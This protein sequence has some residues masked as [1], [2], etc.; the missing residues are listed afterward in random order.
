[1]TFIKTYLVTFIVF[2]AIDLVWLGVIAKD[3]YRKHLGFLM[4]DNVNWAAAIGFYMLFILGL[5]FFALDPALKK[6]SLTYAI[7]VGGFFGLVTYATY[8]MTNLATL[9]DWPVYITVIDIA[10]GTFLCS[11]TTAGSFIILRLLGR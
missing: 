1:M 5:I 3:L 11:M 6:E 7:L 4:A 8:D 9:K 10:W 2:F